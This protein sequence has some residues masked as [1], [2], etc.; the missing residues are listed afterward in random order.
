MLKHPNSALRE[1]NMLKH[2]N[3]PLRVALVG[4]STSS[5]IRALYGDYD[6]ISL[7]PRFR[8]PEQSPPSEV[9]GHYNNYRSAGLKGSALVHAVVIGLIF[10]SAT[11]G[12]HAVEAVKTHEVVTLIAPSPDS[13]ALPTSKIQVSGGGGGFHAHPKPMET[14]LLAWVRCRFIAGGSR[15]NERPVR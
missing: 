14:L 2:Q 3:P 10:A 1:V 15:R 9:W 4:R 8:A 11:F 6:V 13:Y 7:R 5:P 12:H